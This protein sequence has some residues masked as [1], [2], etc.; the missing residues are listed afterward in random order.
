MAADLAKSLSKTFMKRRVKKTGRKIS[1]VLATGT[2]LFTLASAF[3]GT[4]AWFDASLNLTTNT[5]NFEIAVTGSCG[6]DN[7]R[8]IKFDYGTTTYGS[9]ETIDWLTPETGHVNS[10]NYNY[11][12]HSFG[13]DAMNP[14]DPVD[15]VVRGTSL[16]ELNCNAV[17]EVTFVGSGIGTTYFQLSS[18]IFDVI[19]DKSEDILLS[20][21]VDIDIFYEDDLYD[22]NPLF[23]CEDDNNTSL[24]NEYDDLVYFPSYKFR[25]NNRYYRWDGLTWNQSLDV[26]TEEGSTNRGTINYPTYLPESPEVGDYY[27]VLKT[28][29]ALGDV[30]SEIA[31]AQI[32]YK[33]SYLS[34]LKAAN[35][36]SHFYGNPKTSSIDIVENKIISFEDGVPVRFYIN[37]NYAPS[38][39]DTFMRDIFLNDIIAKYDYGF[40]FSFL[41]GPRS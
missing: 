20:D 22:T 6:L 21:C 31:D 30:A 38:V 19:R 16:K 3:T 15:R 2:V 23:V 26:P 14:Y 18:S 27:Y 32:Y 34:S 4:Y 11:E 13:V 40:S 36:H 17:Y 39:A 24:V 7:V 28:P 29:S 8:L 5:G 41:E 25:R 1:V 12:L 10:Y 37:V 35:A 33:I 9:F